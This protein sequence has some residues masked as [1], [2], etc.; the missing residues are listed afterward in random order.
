VLILD[1]QYTDEKY[2]EHIAW[3]H[4]ALSRV[5]S[6]ALEARARNCFSFITNPAHDDRRSDEMLE[7]APA[8][9]GR[10][11]AHSGSGSRP[12]SAEIWLSGAG[13]AR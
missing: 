8:P 10:K 1:T 13:P 7:R 11:R 6:L 4:G 2:Q 12:R 3:G 5:V 9:G